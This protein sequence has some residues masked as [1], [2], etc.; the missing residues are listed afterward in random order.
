M[1][2]QSYLQSQ[3]ITKPQ[4]IAGVVAATLHIP[5][6]WILIYGRDVQP[7]LIGRHYVTER[8]SAPLQNNGIV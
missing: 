4:A 5:L 2:V 6:N 1:C 8:D 3:K 7:T